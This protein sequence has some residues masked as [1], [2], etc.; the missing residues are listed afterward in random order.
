[1]SVEVAELKCFEYVNAIKDIEKFSGQGIYGLD[2]RR[3]EIH[4]SICELMGL[5]REET[6]KVTG[7]LE[8]FD[9][10]GT[11]MYLALLSIK[12]IKENDIAIA[13]ASLKRSRE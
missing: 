6:M 5:T 4:D 10:N 11:D 7:N 2:N 12:R 8:K 13:E 9:N 1:M 3:S